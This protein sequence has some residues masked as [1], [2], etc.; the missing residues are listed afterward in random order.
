M[1]TAIKA[2]LAALKQRIGNIDNYVAK[3]L[4][5]KLNDLSKYFSAE[6]VDA[7][8]LAIDNISN[9]GGFIIG[10]QTGIGKGGSWPG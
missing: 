10:D 9:G 6:Q 4:D 7:L 8:R 2:A 1:G 5:Y 3:Q